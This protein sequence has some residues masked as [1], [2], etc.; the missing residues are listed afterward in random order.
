[1][2]HEDLIFM[3]SPFTFDPSIVDL[4]LAL[5]TGAG[6]LLVNSKLKS[7]PMRLAQILCHHQVTLMQ[8]TPSLFLQFSPEIAKNC[9]LGPSSSLRA[10]LLGG[11]PFPSRNTIRARQHPMNRTQFYNIYGIT[12]VSSWATI[13]H[14]DL[15]HQSPENPG[16][17]LGKPMKSTTI[18]VLNDSGQEITEGEGH[19]HI[20]GRFC[21][22]DAETTDTVP[23]LRPTGDLV[24]LVDGCLYFKGRQDDTVKRMGQ[25]ITLFSVEHLVAESGLVTKACAVLD[26]RKRLILAISLP[27]SANEAEI[28]EKVNEFIKSRASKAE[29]PDECVILPHIPMSQNGKTDRKKVLELL[30][31]QR[32][33]QVADDWHAFLV[34]RWKQSTGSMQDPA[35]GSNFIL[36]GG[37]SMSALELVARM[38]D[39]FGLQLPHLLDIL[40]NRNWAE[41]CDYIRQM[42]MLPA[43]SR[44]IDVVTERTP[45]P[46]TESKQKFEI[47]ILWKFN[48]KKCVDATPFVTG[49]SVFI[50]SHS[51]NFAG[52]DLET[53]SCLWN[54]ELP[55]RIESSATGQGNRI[56]VGCYDGRLYCLDATD[57]S[58]RW[59][60]QSGD[61]V[62]CSPIY[63][64][65]RL[66]FGSHDQHV[67]CLDLDGR[68]VW[69]RRFSKGSVFSRPFCFQ[70]LLVASLDGTCCALCPDTGAI[71]WTLVCPKPIFGGLSV[72]GDNLLIPCVDGTLYCC[73]IQDGRPEWH[74][75][76]GAAIFSTPRVFRD[77]I[78]FGCHD[79]VIYCV[80]GS[81]G[82]ILWRTD[83]S[84][85]VYASPFVCDFNDRHL[86]ICCST[87]GQLMILN[88]QNGVS[89][90]R[91]ELPGEVFS[92]PVMCGDRII[93]G[94]RDNFVYFCQVS[95]SELIE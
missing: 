19:L 70:F 33:F 40:L 28:L 45:V 39:T 6:L 93:I 69:R 10:V 31:G 55:D 49:G 15:N 21:F 76:C 92:S 1:M 75:R 86:V 82:T 62:K 9:L 77:R 36:C 16:I 72:C 52:I 91:V 59:S 3:A 94:C 5:S 54:T 27:D 47:S 84:S 17:S 79:N 20:G 14:V 95:L 44:T 89:L 50:G 80:D 4:F 26:S 83:C 25:R 74:C 90:G 63:Q 2:T 56:F 78:V 61:H 22:V 67:Y 23:M 71:K 43:C 13:T 30:E 37:N 53:G 38:E 8:A 18:C 41:V 73:K 48:L 88:L 46:A 32:R 11:E 35:D 12:E 7:I 58:I 24:T 29:I 66:Y 87:K 68:L 60:F 34:A 85:A 42:P 81:T 57:G 64:N 65:E 51:H